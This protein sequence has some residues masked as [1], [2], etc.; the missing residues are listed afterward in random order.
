MG[1][2]LGGMMMRM[3]RN[4]SCVAH[5]PRTSAPKKR[6]KRYPK[7]WEKLEALTDELLRIQDEHYGACLNARGQ[8]RIAVARNPELVEITK[9]LTVRQTLRLAAGVK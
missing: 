3:A 6:P 8:F 2:S 5:E 1:G 7:Q 9:H 4:M